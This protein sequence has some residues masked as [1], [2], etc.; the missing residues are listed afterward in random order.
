MS[1]VSEKSSRYRRDC[2]SCG[3]SSNE[4]S[5]VRYAHPDWP[6]VKCAT[7][8]L[9]YLEYV[10]SYSALY[11]EIAW[12]HQH[13][14]EEARRLKQSPIFARI[15]MMTRWGLGI[16]AEAT[17]AGGLAAWAKPGPVLDVGCSSGEAFADLPAGYIPNGIEI[18]AGAAEK[19]RAIFEPR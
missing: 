7:C 6:M 16:F 1:S 18:D 10:P 2:P 5:P 13:K 9:I 19:A 4:A 3:A 11:N 8:G 12:T 14:R 17:P 15:D